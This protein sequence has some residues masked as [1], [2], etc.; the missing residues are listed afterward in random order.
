MKNSIIIAAAITAFASAAQAQDAF[1]S[2]LGN[3][4]VAVNYSEYHLQSASNPA[5]QQVIVQLDNDGRAGGFDAANL[6]S[7]TSNSAFTYQAFEDRNNESGPGADLNS[8]VYQNSGGFNQGYNTAV[9]VQ[10]AGGSGAEKSTHTSQILQEGNGNTA[11]N[12]TQNRG[13]LLGSM[14][15]ISL[16]APTLSITPSALGLPT[17]GVSTGFSFGSSI[18]V[19]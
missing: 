17:P 14:T 6:S 3:D 9:A 16:T 4:H 11:V 7:G 19:D 18:T 1:I 12:W 13:G 8:L 5:N 2:Q 15:L 10:L